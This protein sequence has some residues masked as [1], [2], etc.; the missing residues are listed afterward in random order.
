MEINSFPNRLDLNDLNCRRAKES[1]VK[2]CINTDSHTTEQLQVMKL[3]V[4]V[5]RRGWLEKQDVINTLN[6]GPLLKSLKK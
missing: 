3:G 4:S 1:G 5:A 6:L 2:L